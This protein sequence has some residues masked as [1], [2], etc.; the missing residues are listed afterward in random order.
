[1]FK[2]I[3]AADSDQNP[4]AALV[5]GTQ[6]AGETASIELQV[7]EPPIGAGIASDLVAP[8]IESVLTS[9]AVDTVTLVIGPTTDPADV[10]DVVAFLGV[11]QV[12]LE[13]IN[14]T[15][16]TGADG[17]VYSARICSDFGRFTAGT[18]LELTFYAS[19]P[20]S[21]QSAAFV[22][23]ITINSVYPGPLDSCSSTSEL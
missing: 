9:A 19:D 18:N 21:N 12:A 7:V 22:H 23:P 2:A 8:V 5:D 11:Q 10:T 17:M 20:S 6:F 1:M 14:K 16:Q 13:V 4:D 3:F 15:T